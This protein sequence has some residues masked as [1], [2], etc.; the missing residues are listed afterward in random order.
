MLPADVNI[1]CKTVVTIFWQFSVQPWRN[2]RQNDCIFVPLQLSSIAHQHPCNGYRCV[3][4]RGGAHSPQCRIHGPGS[5]H[6]PARWGLCHARNDR[7]SPSTRRR[8]PASCRR[9][10]LPLGQ[11]NV[12]T[13]CPIA[14]RGKFQLVRCS[15]QIHHSQDGL[16]SIN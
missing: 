15:C 12:H 3:L 14:H 8:D 16:E 9:H 10:Q 6:Y 13:R 1:R 5:S 4:P 11:N 2:L 7:P